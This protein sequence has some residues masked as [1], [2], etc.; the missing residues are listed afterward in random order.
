MTREHKVKL[1][2]LNGYESRIRLI[3]DSTKKRCKFVNLIV[4]VREKNKVHMFFS[5]EAYEEE[6]RVFV[7]YYNTLDAAII[8]YNK[9]FDV[10]KREKE[11]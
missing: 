10:L 3:G 5:L 7:E 11:K 1:H 9:C 4:A 8:N 6:K 2:C